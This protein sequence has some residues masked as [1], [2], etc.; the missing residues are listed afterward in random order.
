MRKLLKYKNEIEKEEQ[1]Q[2]AKTFFLSKEE[3]TPAEYKM[4]RTTKT[5]DMPKYLVAKL[6]ALLMEFG[7][8]IHGWNEPKPEEERLFKKSNR[9]NKLRGEAQRRFAERGELDDYYIMVVK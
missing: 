8:D 3:W 6:M 2:P 7:F 4:I 1:K 5:C 9:V